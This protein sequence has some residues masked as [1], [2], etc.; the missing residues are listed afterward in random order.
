MKIGFGSP[1]MRHGTQIVAIKLGEEISFG[2][3]FTPDAIADNLV[4]QAF[5]WTNLGCESPGDF[6]KVAMQKIEPEDEHQ[7]AFTVNLKISL[8]GTY[9]ATAFVV[10]GDQE[11]WVKKDIYWRISL[12]II[13]SLYVRQVP[14]DKAN[15]RQDSD[16]IS[17]MDDMLPENNND[18][19]SE[20]AYTL[21]RLKQT[22]VNCLWIQTPYRVDPWDKRHYMDTAG[23]DYASTDWFSIDP[24]LSRGSRM[25]PAWDTD[26]QHQ[27]ANQKM[28]EFVAAAHEKGMKVVFGIAPNH[29]GHNYI[30]RD[31]VREENIVKRGYYE[32][33]ATDNVR[34][35]EAEE[36]KRQY[37]NTAIAMYAE[38]IYPQ[39]YAAKD[40]FGRYDPNGANSVD[41]TYSPDWYGEWLDTKHLNHGAHAGEHR[42]N[43]STE[44]NWKVLAYIGNAML[45][46]VV[47]LGVDG[48]RIDHSYG[49]PIEF[50]TQ[51]I[52]FVEKD[53]RKLRQDFEAL[54]LIHE[55]HDRKQFS[56]NVG[57]VVQSK[58]YE[59]ILEGFAHR[60]PEKIWEVYENPY[61]AE[62]AG[63]GNHDE[64]RGIQFFNGNLHEFGNAVITMLFMGGPIT[65]LAGDE[66][67]EREQLHFKAKGG[68]PT[69]WQARNKQLARENK[70]LN[71]W[72]SQAGQLRQKYPELGFSGRERLNPQGGP[73][74]IMAFEKCAQ[75]E[76]HCT[77]MVFSNLNHGSEQY[78]HFGLGT[79][80]RSW[81]ESK[82]ANEPDLH[83][84]VR[85]LFSLTPERPLWR[86]P[87]FA[88]D[89]FQ[90]G[91][92]VILAPYQVQV[93]EVFQV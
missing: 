66:Y 72:L 41:E 40:N 45:W 75:E 35:A 36:R 22:G 65:T 59:A 14:I 74:P 43:A 55:D 62:F 91:I 80:V 29:V 18:E 68:I 31:F 56:A 37:A 33:I 46:A 61:F 34:L 87:V 67:G 5:L 19:D 10:W 88:R 28:K 71:H 15:A 27:D 38:Y 23:S 58:W 89:F 52:P 6:R 26:R 9:T 73:F 85:D 90:D 16:E 70:E 4:P 51:T 32:Q 60:N 53:A 82:I 47:E 93:L 7:Y 17:T 13:D 81:I 78:G 49:M 42:W 8:P 79:G 69:L 11:I 20:L 25:I 63:T 44:Q 21:D 64:Q 57:D 12:P 84:Q 54:I 48:F 92:D 86:Y 3:G 77:L 83:L 2:V 39:M 30:F 1:N 76:E 24:E 50:F